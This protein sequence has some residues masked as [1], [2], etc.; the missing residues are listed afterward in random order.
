MPHLRVEGGEPVAPAAL[1][2]ALAPFTVRDETGV[3]RLMACYLEREGE[4]LLLELLA[5]E[6]AKPQHFFA[7]L[8]RRDGAWL[9]RCLPLTD[10]EKTPAV[11]R[12]LALAGLRVAA[13]LPGSRALSED[14]GPELAAM[15]G[16]L[17]PD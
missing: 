1:H 13:C 15:A 10:P 12:L 2:A 8:R 7:A 4:D 3:L 5:A 16:A 14:L 9:L 6:S 11:R 17:P